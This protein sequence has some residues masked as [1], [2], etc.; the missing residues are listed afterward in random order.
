ML[1]TLAIFLLILSLLVF[2]HEFGHYSTARIFG[3][4]VEEF[5][6]G[7]PPRLWGWRP[8]LSPTIYSLNWL[9]LGGFVKIKGEN[10]EASHDAD[11]FAAKP[12]W[13]RLV[14]LAS[15]V[16]MNFVLCVLILSAGFAI[17][18]PASVEG[19]GSQAVIS[20]ASIQIL[21]IVPDS[22]AQA[23]GLRVGDAILA[24]DGQEFSDIDGLQQYLVSRQDQSVMI[25]VR[26][27][28]GEATIQTTVKEFSG[29]TGIG[30]ALAKTA[31]VRYPWYL[32][33]WQGLKAT[34]IWLIAIVLAL[35]GIIKN[36]ISG[37]P[38]GLEVAGPVGIAVLT[39]Q[40]AKLGLVYVMQFTALLS[41]N[42][43]IIN[44]LPFP[45]LDGGRILFLAI[46]KIRGRAVGQRWENFTHN[47][48]FALLMVLIVAVTYRDLLVYGG[49]IWGAVKNLVGL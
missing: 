36:L 13:Q 32:A 9:P 44:I 17:G 5:G 10:G 42:L 37:A 39:G 16:A 28:T 45:A 27:G 31:I 30:V 22:P 23:A 41:L 15:G 7:L 20:S 24:L 26:R 14:I 21:E 12:I 19:L 6:F 25:T 3:I 34:F 1:I 18:L 8:K 49:R 35:V 29:F 4:K 48:G 2:V 43:A 33:V 46:E 38:I 47:L 40:A 11:S